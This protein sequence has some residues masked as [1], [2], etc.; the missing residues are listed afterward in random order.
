MRCRRAASSGCSCGCHR[1]PARCRSGHR[2]VRRL[3]F[4]RR[5]DWHCVVR[6]LLF[7][8][9]CARNLV[10]RLLLF[11][12][13]CARNL[14]VRRLVFVLRRD[15]RRAARRT[16]VGRGRTLCHRHGWRVIGIRLGR[17]RRL[18]ALSHLHLVLGLFERQCPTHWS[19][20]RHRHAEGERPS[21]YAAKS[22]SYLRFLSP[23]R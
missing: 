6:R 20:R 19:E 10:V 7:V 21:Q 23:A 14:V 11:G 8:L 12:L 18:V 15:G 17:S 9:R 4:G 13:R 2:I 5:R 16:L 1:A 22:P 3:L